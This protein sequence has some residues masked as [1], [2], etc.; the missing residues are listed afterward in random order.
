[1]WKRK[2]S[3]SPEISALGENNNLLLLELDYVLKVSALKCQLVP[4][5][6]TLDGNLNRYSVN[7]HQH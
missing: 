1:L 2:S 6:D 4:L 5:I 7:T 3:A